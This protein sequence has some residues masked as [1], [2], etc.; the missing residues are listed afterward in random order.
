MNQ[1]KLDII[2]KQVFNFIGTR[3]NQTEYTFFSD[4]RKPDQDLYGCLYQGEGNSCGGNGSE[5]FLESRRESSAHQHLGNESGS[6]SLTEFG[7]HTLSVVAYVNRQGGT[8]LWSLRK[9]TVLLFQH[10]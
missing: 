9:E 1:E 7:S 4:L 10:V 2:S 5:R 6:S 8:R 3:F